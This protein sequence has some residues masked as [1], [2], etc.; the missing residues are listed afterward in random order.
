MKGAVD[1]RASCSDRVGL[2]SL[3]TLPQSQRLAAGLR[4]PP[5]VPLPCRCRW[6]ADGLAVPAALPAAVPAAPLAG[7]AFPPRATAAPAG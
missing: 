6:S 4:Y 2:A 5:T 1:Q 7:G 3:P